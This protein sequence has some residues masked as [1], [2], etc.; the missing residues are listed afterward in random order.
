MDSPQYDHYGI[1][2]KKKSSLEPLTASSWKKLPYHSEEKDRVNL[3]KNS[4]PQSAPILP[5]THI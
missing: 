5:T 4:C 1:F 3:A 2:G